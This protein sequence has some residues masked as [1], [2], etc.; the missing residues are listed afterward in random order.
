MADDFNINKMALALSGHKLK[1]YSYT[2]NN[3]TRKSAK[4]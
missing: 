4:K 1:K 3:P 2:K